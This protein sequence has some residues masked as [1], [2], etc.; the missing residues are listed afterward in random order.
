MGKNRVRKVIIKNFRAIGPEGVEIDI[1]DIVVLVGQNNTAKTTILKAIKAVTENTG[2]NALS[3]EDFHNRED[4]N[5]PEIIVETIVNDKT[6]LGKE[7]IITDIN[8]IEYV[9]EKWLWED[10]KKPK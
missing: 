1:D 2:E 5:H 6:K 4:H 10:P 8:G 9:K 7:W 3:N